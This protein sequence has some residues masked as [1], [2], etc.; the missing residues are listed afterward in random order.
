MMI[1]SQ[2]RPAEMGHL[3]IAGPARGAHGHRFQCHQPFGVGVPIART[4]LGI[5]MELLVYG[6][7]IIPTLCPA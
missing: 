6:E 2:A 1:S 5:G 4:L 3:D 7:H